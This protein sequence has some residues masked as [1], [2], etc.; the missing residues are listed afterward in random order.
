[1]LIGGI[2][3][4]QGAKT[5][6]GYTKSAYAAGGGVPPQAIAA[7]AACQISHIAAAIVAR[8]GT[9]PP[10][11]Q[12]LFSHFIASYLL[13]SLRLGAFASLRFFDPANQA[14]A[15]VARVITI[16]S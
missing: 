6:R 1:L 16:V 2:D 10:A 14:H 11:A 9:R 5:Q 13:S 12:A 3:K 4:R 7:S 8:R 15:P